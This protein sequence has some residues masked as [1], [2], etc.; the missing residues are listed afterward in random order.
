MVLLIIIPMKNGY[1]IGNIPNI[2]RQTHMIGKIFITLRHHHQNM[3]ATNQWSRSKDKTR[4]AHAMCKSKPRFVQ[5]DV[6]KCPI[7]LCWKIHQY[8]QYVWSRQVKTAAGQEMLG[9]ECYKKCSLLSPQYPYRVREPGS[10]MLGLF[11]RWA[12]LK[13]TVEYLQDFFRSFSKCFF[14][15]RE[16]D[17]KPSSL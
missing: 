14:F 10:P 3:S 15:F 13:V 6:G 8:V 5:Y 12:C 9:N 16:N 11:W 2:F 4:V 1:F 17:E 7:C